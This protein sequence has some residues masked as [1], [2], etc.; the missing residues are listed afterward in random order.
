MEGDSFKIKCLCHPGWLVKEKMEHYGR[1]KVSGERLEIKGMQQ[2]LDQML[3]VEYLIVNEDR[4]QNNFGV[5]RDADSLE[6]LGAAPIYDSGT[7]F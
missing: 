1:E 4:H 3:A 5:L 7:S 2:E 6:W